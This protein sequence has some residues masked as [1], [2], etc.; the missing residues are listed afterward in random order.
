ML[1]MHDYEEDLHDLLTEN[2]ERPA[3][4]TVGAYRA[5]ST[6]QYTAGSGI[7]SKIPPRFDGSTSWFKYEELIVDWLDLTVFEAQ[8]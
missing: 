6:D 4:S 5:K 8:H 1:M 7:T 2:K 3:E